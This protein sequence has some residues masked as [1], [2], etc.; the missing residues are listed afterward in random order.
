MGCRRPPR[1]GRSARSSPSPGGRR[2]AAGR[3]A[4]ATYSP[5]RDAGR[6]SRPSGPA[7]PSRL[8]GAGQSAR[9]AAAGRERVEQQVRHV[10]RAHS[11]DERVVGLGRDRPAP[12]RE[13]G[14]QTGVPERPVAVEPLRPVVRRP[15]EQLRAAPGGRQLGLPD[16]VVDVGT[17]DR[18][19][20][21]GHVRPPVW[22]SRQAA[23]VAGQ[24]L[25]AEV[26][27]VAAGER[28]SAAA[29]RRASNT[30]SEPMCMCAASSASSSSRKVASSG[31][32]RSADTASRAP[33]PRPGRAGCVRLG[34]AGSRHHEHRAR[35]TR[36]RAPLETEPSST[37]RT[38]P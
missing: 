38:G 23:A 29:P 22:G 13:P 24:R 34:P 14:Q 35:G 28:A 25:P 18:S 8:A 12:A 30:I 27:L 19:T 16:V 7:E 17:R 36:E 37:R 15:G 6:A 2:R 11:V 5:L 10:H 9:S 21:A 3:G 31:V 33:R 20:Q 32:S 1:R 4:R 26:E